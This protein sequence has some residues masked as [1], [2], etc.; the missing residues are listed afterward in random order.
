MY[1]LHR[2]FLAIVPLFLQYKPPGSV[3]KAN[4]PAVSTIPSASSRLPQRSG[5]GQSTGKSA[6]VVMIDF[7]VFL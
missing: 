6:A 7:Q 1:L 5:S 2:L 3:K 4:T